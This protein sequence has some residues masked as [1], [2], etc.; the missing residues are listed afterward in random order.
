MSEGMKFL[1]QK[2][3]DERDG[4]THLRGSLHRQTRQRG[5]HTSIAM[6]ISGGLKRKEGKV[7]TIDAAIHKHNTCGV[8]LFDAS[9]TLQAS[10]DGLSRARMLST[11]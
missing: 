10:C 1:H 8:N 4:L 2:T 7:A 9:L 5:W 11:S 6:P 3:S